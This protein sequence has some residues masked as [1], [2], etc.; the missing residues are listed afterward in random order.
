MANFYNLLQRDSTNW[1][2]CKQALTE[3]GINMSDIPTDG[4][5]DKIR[6]IAMHTSHDHDITPE[7]REFPNIESGIAAGDCKFIVM[8]GNGDTVSIKVTASATASLTVNWGDGQTSTVTMTNNINTT[9]T[10]SHTYTTW[11]TTASGRKYNTVSFNAPTMTNIDFVKSGS[12]FTARRILW[13]AVKST[14]LT[15]LRCFATGN[16]YFASMLSLYLDCPNVILSQSLLVNAPIRRVESFVIAT[17]VTHSAGNSYFGWPRLWDKDVILTLSA[18]VDFLSFFNQNPVIRNITLTDCDTAN[19]Y[20]SVCQNCISLRSFF[21]NR[22]SGSFQFAFSGC[23]AL[24]IIDLSA[25]ATNRISSF[26]NNTNLFCLRSLL[27]P[28]YID[29]NGVRQ[30]RP[31][32]GITSMGAIDISNSGLMR[33]ALVEMFRSL[34]VNATAVNCTI[35]GS[36]GAAD[37]TIEDIAIATSKNWVVIR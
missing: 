12:L 18:Q 3:K 36:V 17:S 4:F 26:L 37:L 13:M 15:G 7:L 29:G 16:S 25:D 33:E 21:S 35:T 14:T 31:L 20:Q 2:N 23:P 1:S 34:P 6:Q 11:Q 9:P 5:A 28:S 30:P 8:D 19:S 22:A 10:A 24:V 32:S 27:F